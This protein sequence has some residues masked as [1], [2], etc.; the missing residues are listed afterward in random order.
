MVATNSTW[1]RNSWPSQLRQR[2]MKRKTE[3]LR[4]ALEAIL[5]S[6]FFSFHDSDNRTSQAP[7]ATR[8]PNYMVVHGTLRI[9]GCWNAHHAEHLETLSRALKTNA[10]LSVVHEAFVSTG[11]T[12][13]RACATA[14]N[15]VGSTI[16]YFWPCRLCV[17]RGRRHHVETPGTHAEF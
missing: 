3:L 8:D 9:K 7:L 16:L 17:R 10:P 14:N 1:R 6:Q 15:V 12:A 13:Q 4:A 2:M 11:V 5:L